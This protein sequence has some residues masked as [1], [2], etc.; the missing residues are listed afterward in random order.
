MEKRRP[1]Y[2]LVDIKTAFANPAA[3][4]RTFTSKQDADALGMTDT[5]VVAAIQTLSN[6]D[7]DKSMTSVASNKIWQDVYKPT[8]AGQPL[9]VKFTLDA[10]GSYLLI[11]FKR[12]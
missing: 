4:N 2:R 11:S 3:L 1:H 8:V 6:S 7:F 12:L 10:Q 5:D 9:Y